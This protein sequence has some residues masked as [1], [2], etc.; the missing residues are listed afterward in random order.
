MFGTPAYEPVLGANSEILGYRPSK[1]QYHPGGFE[2]I[3][4]WITAKKGGG[5]GGGGNIPPQP[6]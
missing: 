3:G 4:T 5:G 2:K 6:S 1:L